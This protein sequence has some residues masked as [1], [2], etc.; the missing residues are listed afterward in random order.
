MNA[1]LD[2]VIKQ[3]NGHYCHVLEVND[4]YEL[5]SILEQVV[6]EFNDEFSDEEIQEFIDTLNIYC[7]DETQEEEV[8]N[9][10]FKI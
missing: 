7:L 3:R 5:E 9:Y 6:N 8:Y 1:I 10:Q 4:V 2:K